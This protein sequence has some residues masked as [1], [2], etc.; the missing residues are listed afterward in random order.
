MSIVYYPIIY[1]TATAYV[2]WRREGLRHNLDGRQKP[3]QPGNNILS[4]LWPQSIAAITTRK[5]A[6][7]LPATRNRLRNFGSSIDG[8]AP[9]C[10]VLHGWSKTIRQLAHP[11]A[12]RV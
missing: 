3:P 8:T 9:F 4:K 1:H 10:Y 7:I 2:I 6:P 5:T 11:D 12:S